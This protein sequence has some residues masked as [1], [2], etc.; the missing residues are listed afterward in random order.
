MVGGGGAVIGRRDPSF[1]IIKNKI[2][3]INK[4]V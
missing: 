2:L 3:T 1:K 4:I